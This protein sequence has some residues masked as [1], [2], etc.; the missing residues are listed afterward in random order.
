MKGI[1]KNQLVHVLANLSQEFSNLCAPFSYVSK[2]NSFFVLAKGAHVY[3][4]G[5][6]LLIGRT[7]DNVR[8]HGRLKDMCVPVVGKKLST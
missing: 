1:T 8:Y 7:N 2:A 3:S 6:H 4:F 5:A